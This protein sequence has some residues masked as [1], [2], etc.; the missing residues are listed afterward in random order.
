[1]QISWAHF[2]EWEKEEI[3]NPYFK[4]FFSFVIYFSFV[5]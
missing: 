1:M 4:L 5:A 2:N 3:F